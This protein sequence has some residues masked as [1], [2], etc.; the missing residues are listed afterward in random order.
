MAVSENESSGN[1]L[2]TAP[3][4][5]LDIPKHVRSEFLTTFA[6]KLEFQC[7]QPLEPSTL[8]KLESCPKLR[9]EILS[10]NP[11]MVKFSGVDL[12]EEAMAQKPNYVNDITFKFAGRGKHGQYIEDYTK[13]RRETYKSSSLSPQ[14]TRYQSCRIFVRDQQL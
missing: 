1:D 8:L 2:E 11:L 6:N 13:I 7:V 12:T 14:R 5:K 3:F 9:G 10:M 4:L